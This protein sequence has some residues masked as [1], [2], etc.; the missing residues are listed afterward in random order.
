MRDAGTRLKG[1]LSA[2]DLF[3]NADRHRRVVVLRREGPG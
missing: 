1:F 2:F 3:G